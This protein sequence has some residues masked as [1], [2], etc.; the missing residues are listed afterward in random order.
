[1]NKT[2]NVNHR[3]QADIKLAQ[4]KFAYYEKV[5]KII[6][7]NGK[8]Y[9]QI[10]STAYKKIIHDIQELILPAIR[11]NCP[12]CENFCCKLH[13]PEL[14]IYTAGSVGAFSFADYI[15]VRCDTVL[16]EPNFRN[17]EKNLCPFWVGGCNLPLDC[18]SYLCIKWFCNRLK[19]ELDMQVISKHLETLKSLLKDFSIQKCLGLNQ[20]P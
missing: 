5:Y 11:R 6:K 16:P 13:N 7:G 2:N 9:L 3:L 1:M 18:R 4:K 8:E 17:M 12:N 10:Q 20:C 15:L 14:S 19:K